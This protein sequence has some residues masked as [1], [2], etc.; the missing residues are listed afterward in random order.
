MPTAGL[1]A[2]RKGAEVGPPNAYLYRD[3]ARLAVLAFRRD[4][5]PNDW[6]AEALRYMQEAVK[7]GLPVT[8]LTRDGF[9]KSVFSVDQIEQAV[10]N[11]AV[12]R[13]LGPRSS[14]VL[15]PVQDN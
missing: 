14:F 8:E 7:N 1:A 5:H 11:M 3:G 15:E 4:K 13:P 10:R 9:L 6:K 12:A 2:V